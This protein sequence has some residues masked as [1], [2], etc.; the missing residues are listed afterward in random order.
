MPVLELQRGVKSSQNGDN[1]DHPLPVS[2][3]SSSFRPFVLRR[4]QSGNCRF[5]PPRV[6]EC[7]TL[8]RNFVKHPDTHRAQRRAPRAQSPATQHRL[9]PTAGA[10]PGS[11]ASRALGH[12]YINMQH[13]YFPLRHP[14]THARWAAPGAAA[15]RLGGVRMWIAVPTAGQTPASVLA[16]RLGGWTRQSAPRAA[17][18]HYTGARVVAVFAR[19]QMDRRGAPQIASGSQCK[20]RSRAR[21]SF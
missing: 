14:A 4:A 20:V 5:F 21:P 1:E 13:V 15:P 6:P 12:A 18:E 7:R 9:V 16:R 10:A 2:K 17:S 11:G 19:M 8:Y 3:F